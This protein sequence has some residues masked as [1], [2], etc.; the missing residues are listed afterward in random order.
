[1][2][3]CRCAAE[4]KKDVLASGI[5]AAEDPEISPARED[6]VEAEAVVAS[7]VEQ[8]AE[9]KKKKKVSPTASCTS[10][11]LHAHPCNLVE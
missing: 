8:T 7:A 2:T 4:S 11:N 6:P 10:H 1:M 9:K 5:K 3:F